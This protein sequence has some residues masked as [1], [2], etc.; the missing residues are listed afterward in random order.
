MKNFNFRLV[1]V[2]L[3]FFYA[4]CVGTKTHEDDIK[5]SVK[6]LIIKN[7]DNVS[8]SRIKE[9]KQI[10][11]E[12]RYILNVK[13]NLDVCLVKLLKIVERDVKDYSSADGVID[14]MYSV[15]GI[16]AA[17]DDV[18]NAISSHI[19]FMQTH[20]NE[21]KEYNDVLSYPYIKNQRANKDPNLLPAMKK[22]QEQK[23]LFNKVQEDYN[24]VLVEVLK[25]AGNNDYD[26]MMKKLQGP[27]AQNF[28]KAIAE[29]VLVYYDF[30]EVRASRIVKAYNS[31]MELI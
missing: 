12:V 30:E 22:V 10:D 3:C 29:L 20:L 23:L 24:L 26:G 2:L 5:V 1:L 17:L 7:R 18:S 16:T 6:E 9:C 13:E 31:Y 25:I 11:D 8:F 19:I 21:V 27:E 15:R 4:S 14:Y 28:Y